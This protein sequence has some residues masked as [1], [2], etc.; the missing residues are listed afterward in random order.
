[1]IV[2]TY[3]L[4]SNILFKNHKFFLEIFHIG[5]NK[6]SCNEININSHQ[7]R[8]FKTGFLKRAIATK[9]T[10]HEDRF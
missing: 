4:A 9:L 3:C 8:S 5:S 7:E 2:E 10:L 1:M 6:K